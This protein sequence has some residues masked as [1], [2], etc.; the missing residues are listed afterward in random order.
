[1]QTQIST[2]T[3]PS[4][5]W[6]QHLRQGDAAAYEQIFRHYYPPLC[7]YAVSLAGNRDEAEELVQQV[8][9]KIWE[10]H[11]SIDV[12]SSLK[13]YLYRAVHNHFMNLARKRKVRMM[14]EDTMKHLMPG[15]QAPEDRA[16]W[17]ELQR[18]LE[19]ALQKLPEQCRLIFRLNR[20]EE[21]RYREIAEM[22]GLSVKTVENQMGKALRILRAELADYLPMLAALG[23]IQL[24]N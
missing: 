10:M 9:V 7:R 21:L 18:K 12:Q 24:F 22:L 11:R 14:Y 5:Q 6:L 16:R 23:L 1:M 19:A 13:S 15:A 17:N 20:F 3:D 4:L 2:E 8:F